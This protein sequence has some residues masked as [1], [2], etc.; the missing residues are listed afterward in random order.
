M[1]SSNEDADTHHRAF[2]SFSPQ[3]FLADLS[4]I[5]LDV[6]AD[7]FDDLEQ[8]LHASS[9]SEDAKAKLSRVLLQTCEATLESLLR[10]AV[11]F[12]RYEQLTSLAVPPEL[13]VEQPVPALTEPV[14]PQQEAQLDNELQDLR[15]QVLQAR[16][17]NQQLK[18]QVTAVQKDISRAG[19]TSA[20]YKPVIETLSSATQPLLEEAAAI[21]DLAAKLQ[22]M[23]KRAQQLQAA[24]ERLGG[25]GGMSA[26][27]AA[28]A[29]VGD[30][31]VEGALGSLFLD[32]LVIASSIE[33]RCT[34][35]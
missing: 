30:G 19:G 9:L 35:F 2:F 16:L 7:G 26:A 5:A 14:D 10:A 22:P 1:D 12:E 25:D 11:N 3:L 21:R 8:K 13:F 33:G 27:L 6:C 4:N 34:W 23:V 32:G 17:R 18:Q 20:A 24:R 31:V 29:G 28:V 15:D